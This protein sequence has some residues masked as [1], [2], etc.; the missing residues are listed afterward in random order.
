[1]AYLGNSLRDRRGSGHFRARRARLLRVG[2]VTAL[3][4]CSPTL[5]WREARPGAS[6]VMLLM[7]CKPTS[8][9]RRIALDGQSAL[10]TL[11]ACTAGGQTWSLAFA[12]VGDPARM[13]GVLQSLVKAAGANVSASTR[14]AQLLLVPGAT[15]NA[16]SQ[17]VA[18]EGQLADGQVV[19][20]RVAVFARGTWAFQATAVGGALPAEGVQ[21]FM[22]SIRFA[23]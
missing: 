18:Y 12:D 11:Y 21:T 16:A 5:D 13:S 9:E 7:P 17:L 1:M 10:L 6:G 8:Q 4:G 22:E 20:M 15:P 3:V 14:R 2:L 23:N 19:Q